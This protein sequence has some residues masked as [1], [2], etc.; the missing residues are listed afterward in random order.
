MDKMFAKQQFKCAICGKI[1]DDLK[2]RVACETKCIKQQEEAAKKAAEAKKQ[3][4]QQ[5]HWAKVQEAKEYYKKLYNEYIEN[6]DP[7]APD[8]YY[9]FADVVASLMGLND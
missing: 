7:Y 3:E 1:F 6:Y 9:S 4:E 5:A 2:D 8:C